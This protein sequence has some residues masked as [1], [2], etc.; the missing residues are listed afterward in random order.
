MA[1]GLQIS[2]VFERCI[3]LLRVPR[4]VRDL[5]YFPADIGG[6]V[7]DDIPVASLVQVCEGTL[8]LAWACLMGLNSFASRQFAKETGVSGADFGDPQSFIAGQNYYDASAV[9][10]MTSPF[11]YS[12]WSA[13]KERVA[14][15]L[16]CVDL[17]LAE[18][19]TLVETEARFAAFI[20]S[21]HIKSGEAWAHRRWLVD[22]ALQ[23]INSGGMPSG[24]SGLESS[25]LDLLNTELVS[26]SIAVERRPRNYHAWTHRLL[27]ARA[28][29][30]VL[31]THDESDD[32]RASAA[33]AIAGLLERE[34]L[35]TKHRVS[36][37][38][39]HSAMHYRCQLLS[40]ANTA[41]GACAI[42]TTCA[43]FVLDEMHLIGPLISI[44]SLPPLP[45]DVPLARGIATVPPLEH[46]GARYHGRSL[47]SLAR[48]HLLPALE[49]STR[50]RPPKG[51][52]STFNQAHEL[53][54]T[55]RV[56]LSDIDAVNGAT[57]PGSFVLPER[58]TGLLELDRD[59]DP[60]PS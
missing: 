42:L 41:C 39:D 11:H 1:T 32:R 16:R 28:S 38:Q 4:Q 22:Q 35:S 26:C 2:G 17:G 59:P 10:L 54:G 21:R 6:D 45:C 25:V 48:A 51:G 8:G 9:L 58:F 49:A 47:S 60:R 46:M 18:R 29:I 33:T 3:E 24:A 34:F 55:L 30:S 12:A 14:A 19:L 13:R 27:C 57:R 44:G 23:L 31:S 20:H 43:K 40:A 5:D 50:D 53:H 56:A 37:L 15:A 52:D 36:V 7:S